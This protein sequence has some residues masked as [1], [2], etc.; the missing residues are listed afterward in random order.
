[1]AADFN[2]PTITGDAYVDVLGEIRAQFEVVSTMSYGDALN[3][4]VGAVQ[5]LDGSLQKWSGSSFDVV[6]VSITGGGTG[7]STA[8]GART[9]L[10]VNEKGTLAAQVRSNAESDALYV[11]QSRTISTAGALN[12][13]NSLDSNISLTVNSA[14]TSQ[15]G[16]VQL[17]N[18]LNSTSTTQALTAAQGKVLNDIQYSQASNI[19]YLLDFASV[20]IDYQEATISASGTLTGGDAKIVKVG[21]MVTISGKFLHS[22]ST[23]RASNTGAIPSWGRPDSDGAL[24]CY[25]FE[26]GSNT[27]RR[28][29]VNSNGQ[30]S[31]F[32]TA[33]VTDTLGFTISYTI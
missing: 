31:F 9:A 16:V 30:I 1:M 19:V 5:F 8:A 13:G 7:A 26:D 29:F 18:G 23:L 17:F 12:G 21:N 4:K 25:V 33:S 24:N 10:N 28:V 14:T 3:T 15:Q 6:P 32:Y 20:T 2:K 22:S 11:P 27:G